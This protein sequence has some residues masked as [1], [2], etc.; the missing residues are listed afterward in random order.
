MRARKPPLSAAEKKALVAA[1]AK[2][3]RNASAPYS[4]F[5][6]GAALLADDGR[7]FSGAQALKVGLV[8]Q[9]G[10]LDLATRRAW[11]RGGQTG[12]PRVSQV[13]PRRR[14]RILELLGETLLAERPAW[15]GGLLYLYRGALPE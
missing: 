15:I 8:D 10:G 1:A 6:V 7:V 12:E 2:A 9:L 3:R 13:H 4:R 14:Y 11:E 5:R